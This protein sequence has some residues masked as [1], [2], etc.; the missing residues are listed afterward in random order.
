MKALGPVLQKS[1]CTC[2]LRL[3]TCALKEGSFS[4][5]ASYMEVHR[6]LTRERMSP[7][8]T[9]RHWGSELSCWQGA[10]GSSRSK[11]DL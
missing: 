10:G 11:A 4:F 1:S 9:W 8:H 7:F 2:D 3:R 6:T 5:G